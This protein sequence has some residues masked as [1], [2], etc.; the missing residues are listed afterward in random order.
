MFNQIETDLPAHRPRPAGADLALQGLRV[1]DFT[2]FIAGPF[3]TMILADMGA[4]VIK[5]EAPGKGDDFRQY[6]PIVP[7]FGGG[8][9]YAWTNRNKR[10]I[11]LNLKSP[12]GLVL[13]R[14]L[15]SK[16]DVVV[17]NFST[18]VI[19]RLGLGYET[20]RESNP[21]L[22]FCSVSAYG[23]K[24]PFAD[25]LGFD[26]IAQAES[27]FISMNGYPDREGVRALSPVMDISTAMM[28]G[29]AILGALMART[30]T[31]KGQALEVALF[32]TAVLMTGYAP[33]QQ[34]YTGN[35][36]RRPGNTSPDT[37]PSGVFRASDCS[38]LI[39]CGNTKI[40]ER[41]MI[42]VVELPQVAADPA[43]ATNKDRIARREELFALLQETFSKHPWA[44]WQTRMREAAVPCGVLRSV[45]EAIRSPEA[46]SQEVV[47]RIDHPDLGWVPNVSLPIRYSGTP[48]ADPVPAPKVGEHTGEV[49]S[50]WLGYD[51]DH[52]R[53][54]EQAGAFDSAPA[55]SA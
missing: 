47:T 9:P 42:Q 51:H 5:V 30:R 53:G 32:D 34:L 48:L 41:L 36:P 14:E 43:Y 16:A 4:D 54:L 10:S 26:P 23:R 7:E 28:A 44:Y 49:L 38:F 31:G 40:F 24:G 33:L 12:Q 22:I 17:E 6:P 52:I 21:G 19:E 45:G 15:I 11:A 18:G 39:N 27:G 13:A 8:V 35:E 37:C 3:A 29:N 25:R 1:V 20:F 2:H 46:Q 55:R 50:E